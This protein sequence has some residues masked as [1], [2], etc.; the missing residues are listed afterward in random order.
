MFEMFA[1][2]M[3]EEYKK[4]TFVNQYGFCCYKLNLSSHELFFSDLYIS[5]EYR[6]GLEAKK[7]FTKF[8]EFAK[9][10]GCKMITGIVALGLG[11]EENKRKAKLLRCY[12]SLGFVPVKTYENNQ[13]LLKM[14]L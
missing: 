3:K 8:M 12:L 4:D 7:F 6:G 13:I 1:G 2:Y 10:N 5:P 11:D 14:D 9:E